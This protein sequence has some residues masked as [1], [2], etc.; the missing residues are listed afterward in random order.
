MKKKDC[1]HEE[2]CRDFAVSVHRI[3][4]TECGM[5]LYEIIGD[6]RKKL[7]KTRELCGRTR[8]WIHDHAFENPPDVTSG[9]ELLDEL[10]EASI[11]PKRR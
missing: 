2:T 5:D 6:L 9:A 11:T 1:L 7:L 3:V 8:I 4:C 10:E